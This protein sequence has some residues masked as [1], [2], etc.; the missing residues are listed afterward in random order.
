MPI[1]NIPAMLA[2]ILKK[3][4]HEFG[5]NVKKILYAKN[6]I[7]IRKINLGSAAIFN[8]AAMLEAILKKPNS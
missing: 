8:I 5:A 2:A 7:E 3:Q 1:F 6:P 4:V